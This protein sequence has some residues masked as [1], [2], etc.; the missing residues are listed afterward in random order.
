MTKHVGISLLA[1]A[2][3]VLV[4]APMALAK[5]AR[6]TAAVTVT[7]GKPSEFSF[8]LSTKK[9][10]HGA[11]TFTVTNGGT[12]PHDF[13]VCSAPTTKAPTDTCKGKGTPL[14][15]P[16]SS[17][18]LKITFSKAGKYEYL[19]TVPGHATA[20]MKGLLTVT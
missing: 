18:T 3:A 16:G 6:T 5:P 17:K 8:K 20:G 11:V 7:A 12:V 4:A 10:A 1:L 14:I 19:C 9:F 15:T 13:K 2:A